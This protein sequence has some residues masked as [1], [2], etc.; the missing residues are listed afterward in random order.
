MVNMTSFIRMPYQTN[1][2]PIDFLLH[3]APPATIGK[4]WK[5]N[6]NYEPSMS[7]AIGSGMSTGMSNSQS[8]TQNMEK[9]IEKMSYPS[10]VKSKTL[11]DVSAEGLL[12]NSKLEPHLS[13][14]I[15]ESGQKLSCFKIP[16]KY[17]SNPTST[18][19]QHQQQAQSQQQTIFATPIQLF[20]QSN[21]MII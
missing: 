6:L 9:S 8:I 5:I 7:G 16:L 21:S 1:Q 13:R 14:M 20:F 18:A 3:T 19:S 10:I 12:P 17:N 15:N 4:K 11:M 2:E